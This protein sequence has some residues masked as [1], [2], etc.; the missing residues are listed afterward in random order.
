MKGSMVS[1]LSGVGLAV[2]GVLSWEAMRRRGQGAAQAGEAAQARPARQR[3]RRAQLE[4]ELNSASL[5]ELRRLG[6]DGE[7]VDRIVEHRPYRN[8]LDLVSQ[9]VI[10]RE[11]YDAIK[12]SICIRA[13]NEA[14]KIA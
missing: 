1:F 3:S 11:M 2:A 9:L 12:H 10:P 4:V 13:T 14:V 8:K 6:L 5:D 7:A